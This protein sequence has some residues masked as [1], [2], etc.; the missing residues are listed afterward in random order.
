L[1]KLAI[2]SASSAPTI[3]VKKVSSLFRSLVCE[4]FFQ[5]VSTNKVH[6]L[7]RKEFERNRNESRPEV[8]EVCGCT[9]GSLSYPFNL[10]LSDPKK[11]RRRR[12]DALPILCNA[13]IPAPSPFL[14]FVVIRFF[15]L[16]DSLL[17]ADIQQGRQGAGCQRIQ[18]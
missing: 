16:S 4:Q 13:P 15:V 2:H 6:G 8:V 7:I 14:I 5:S 18:V 3:N 9:H 17:F 10:F 12:S 11:Q 1:L